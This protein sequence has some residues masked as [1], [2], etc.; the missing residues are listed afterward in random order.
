NTLVLRLDL[1]RHPR[2]DQALGQV[3]EAVLGATEHQDL[4]FE[5]LVEELAPMR[6]ARYTPLFQV[7]FTLQ[8]AA[9][10]TPQLPGLAVEPLEIESG[11]A[12]L[13]LLLGVAGGAEGLDARFELS[14]DL[15][16]AATI[17]RLAASFETLLQGIVTDP[18][19]HF[20]E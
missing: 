14:T 10:G 12:K 18:R 15:F 8:N 2:F 5:K 19:R 4:P 20:S 9:P 11:L 17:E 13:D 16:D 1:S 3:R 6:D 7:M